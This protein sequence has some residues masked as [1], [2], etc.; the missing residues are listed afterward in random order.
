MSAVAKRTKITRYT[1]Y[2]KLKNM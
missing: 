2:R 1:L